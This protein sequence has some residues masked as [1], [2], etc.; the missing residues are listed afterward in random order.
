MLSFLRCE[1]LEDYNISKAVTQKFATLAAYSTGLEMQ[2]SLMPLGL[3]FHGQDMSTVQLQLPL[4]SLLVNVCLQ[5][6]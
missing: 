2:V 3:N 4:L 6:C 5:L 1:I